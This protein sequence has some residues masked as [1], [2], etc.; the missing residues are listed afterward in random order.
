MNT[1]LWRF[2][3]ALIAIIAS[4]YVHADTRANCTSIANGRG[5]AELSRLSR[6]AE[7]QSDISNASIKKPWQLSSISDD[8]FCYGEPCGWWEALTSPHMVDPTRKYLFEKDEHVFVCYAVSTE[9]Y[10]LQYI[11]ILYPET[12][13]NIHSAGISYTCHYDS[14]YSD[15]K[16]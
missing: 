5:N 12:Y 9:R 14:R 1:W 4:S 6:F 15:V 16:C 3:M 7:F 13:I 8:K 11:G 10:G 2:W